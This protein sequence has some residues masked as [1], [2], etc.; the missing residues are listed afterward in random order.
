MAILFFTKSSIVACAPLKSSNQNHIE[1]LT[2]FESEKEYSQVFV[3][4][5]ILKSRTGAKLVCQRSMK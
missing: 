4:H 1:Y 3:E 5:Q 2:G